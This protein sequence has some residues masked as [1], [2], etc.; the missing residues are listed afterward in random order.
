MVP[1][2][3]G[4]FYIVHTVLTNI[5]VSALHTMHYAYSTCLTF[6]HASGYSQLFSLLLDSLLDSL[7]L[8]CCNMVGNGF[9]LEQMKEIVDSTNDLIGYV[10]GTLPNAVTNHDNIVTINANDESESDS[11][12]DT[13]SIQ[14]EAP[15]EIPADK[16]IATINHTDANHDSDLDS[17]SDTLS[18]GSDAPSDIPSDNDN[19]LSSQ[20]STYNESETYEIIDELLNE[21]NEPARPVIPIVNYAGD[22][23]NA[24]DYADGWEWQLE[25]KGSS[26]GPFLLDSKLNKQSNANQ[27]KTF[28]EALFDISMWTTLA[29]ETNNYAC[30]S[31]AK[32]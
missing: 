12:S 16:D 15:P 32:T 13:L 31:T 6:D 17:D 23:E 27:P 28:F 5:F 19:T 22:I 3:V 11:H 21:D 29:Q 14:P 10:S 26:C 9:E 8:F 25:D 1:S 18:I 24:D 2:E 20:E 7:L 30:Q 4:L